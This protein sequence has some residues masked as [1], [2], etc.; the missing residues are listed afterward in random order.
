MPGPD[1]HPAVTFL[2]IF[3]LLRVKPFP[4]LADEKQPSFRPDYQAPC[5]S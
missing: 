4:E 2:P 1:C 3:R 5:A